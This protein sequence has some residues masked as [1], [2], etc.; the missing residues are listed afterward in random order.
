MR[1]RTSMFQKISFVLREVQKL[2]WEERMSL[3]DVGL[4]NIVNTC[5]PVLSL[6]QSEKSRYTVINEDAFTLSPAQQGIYDN[7]TNNY[8]SES[9][10][11]F[12][13]ACAGSGK[14][15][16]AR[17][18][19][20][21][22]RREG[23]LVMVC[24]PTAKAAGQYVGA[25]TCHKLFGIP[26]KQGQSL[27]HNDEKHP[28]TQLILQSAMIVLDELSM[29][30]QSNLNTIDLYLRDV[31]RV[32]KPFGGRCILFIGDF[33]QLPPV[34][35]GRN[36]EES[37]LSNSC[38]TSPLLRHMVSMTLTEVLRSI[39]PS[40]TGW[41]S[42]LSHG[43][44]VNGFTDVKLPPT[45]R[46]Y[47]TPK[48]SLAD[49]LD[50]AL[51]NRF[52][53][54]LLDLANSTLYKSCIVAFT[55]AKVDSYND[56]VSEY[57][58]AKYRLTTH[59]C[60]AQHE[61]HQTPGNLLNLDMMA[62]YKDSTSS[63]PASTLVLFRGALVMLTRN[64]MASRGL[65]NGSVFIVDAVHKN[66]VHVINVSGSRETNPHYGSNEILFR[67]TFPVDESGIKFTRKQYPLKTI[68]AGT[69]HRLQGETVSLQGRLLV[70]VTFPAF[71][72]GQAYVTFSRARTE[73]QIYA[74][75]REDGHFTSLTYSRMLGNPLDVGFS[76]NEVPQ[77]NESDHSSDSDR[78]DPFGGTGAD[79]CNSNPE[80]TSD[81]QRNAKRLEN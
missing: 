33:A 40:F 38:I 79:W 68:Y 43:F 20:N 67:F 18:I 9:N 81:N 8:R 26:T 16:V 2:L 60:I 61:A 78:D 53:R 65:V 63:L 75:C 72:H 4:P 50:G 29:L 45:I 7:V 52:P 32:N 80:S 39:S 27:Y 23:H 70:D 64:F 13:R 17:K 58:I 69:T 10:Q 48:D 28:L 51:P 41:L 6:V 73:S 47:S 49:Y 22:L 46:K 3:M 57:I 35:K 59:K 12:L 71:L 44:G 76:P 56:A 54:N 25:F 77:S 15:V 5:E 24:A 1:I 31:T 30:L 62:K 42:H 19:V 66:T 74:V 11:F 37:T 21:H 36:D 34:V 14:T 55:N